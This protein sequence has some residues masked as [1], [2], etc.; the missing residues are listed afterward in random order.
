MYKLIQ[1]MGVETRTAEILYRKHFFI[2]PEH[3]MRMFSMVLI[4]QQ[5]VL[6][7]LTPKLTI[8]HSI[9]NNECIQNPR[10]QTVPTNVGVCFDTTH[11]CR[12]TNN[13]YGHVELRVRC[14]LSISPRRNEVKMGDAAKS[15]KME[16]AMGKIMMN[17]GVL[18]YPI[19]RQIQ[20][21][22]I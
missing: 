15:T 1:I 21:T 11:K 7:S 6:R 20:T 10:R 5:V 18:G 8:Q 17:Q 14:A 13:I 16:R 4:L 19:L 22:N 2:F 9:I 3:F 12:Y